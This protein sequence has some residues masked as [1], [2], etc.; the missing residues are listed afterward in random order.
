MTASEA[1]VATPVVAIHQPNYL[2]WLGYFAKMARSD[3]FVFL[4]DVQFSKGSF[5]NRVKIGTL[6]DGGRWLTVPIRVHLGN[7]ISEILPS[8]SDWAN[9]HVEIL[10]DAYR[11]APNFKNVFPELEAIFSDAARY[12]TLSA[13]NINIVTAIARRLDTE[14]VMVN[15][16]TFSISAQSDD[17]LIAI[18]SAISPSATYLSGSGGAAYQDPEK[19]K[20]AGLGFRYINFE[21]PIYDQRVETGTRLFT[22][23]LS[24]VDAL[25]NIGWEQ[26]SNLIR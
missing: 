7:L 26:T 14:C 5:S 19:F 21:H 1:A 8:S 18:V 20:R 2:P 9:R 15:S 6:H 25:F 11:S 12:E 13:I 10:R 23:G 16:S 4:D 17:R 3:V 24:I 22:P